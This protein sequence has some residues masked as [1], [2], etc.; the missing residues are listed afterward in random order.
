[1]TEAADD[2]IARYER[3]RAELSTMDDEA[4][5]ERFWSLCGQIMSPVVDLART[6]T[7][8]S[9][10]RSVLLRMGIAS[11]T[12]HAVVDHIYQENLLGKGAGHV[13]WKL[14]QRDGI[15][16]RQAAEAIAHDP[17]VLEGLFEGSSDE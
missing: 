14:A 9:I 12:T 3:L 13:V 16:I 5:K 11:T 8:V 4:L 6:H 7:S 1:M 15:D 10:E 2:R 17:A